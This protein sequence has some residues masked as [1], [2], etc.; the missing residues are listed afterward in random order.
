M[1]QRDLS[2]IFTRLWETGSITAAD[3]RLLIADWRSGQAAAADEAPPAG[4]R[5]NEAEYW[6]LRL[7]RDLSRALTDGRGIPDADVGE[8]LTEHEQALLARQRR[9]LD[10]DPAAGNGDLAS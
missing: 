2:E 6:S 4:S 5:L 10:R 7:V 1:T 9:A 3:R 8:L